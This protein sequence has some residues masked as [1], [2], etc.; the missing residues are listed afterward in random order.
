MKKTLNNIFLL[1]LG[2]II[3]NACDKIEK[4][5]QVASE[6]TSTRKVMIEEFTGHTCGNCPEG[7]LVLQKLTQVLGSQIVAISVHAGSF[8]GS[9]VSGEK[10]RTEF[11][12]QAGEAVAND[13]Q[14]LSYPIATV[15]RTLFAGIRKLPSGAWGTKAS[16]LLATDADITMDITATLDTASRNL[17]VIVNSK[18]VNALSGQYSISIGLIEDSIVDYQK[19]YAGQ[20]VYLAT[21]DTTKYQTDTD[22]PDYMHR[23]VFRGNLN[24]NW[25]EAINLTVPVGQSVE[26]VAPVNTINGNFNLE[27]LSVIA[28]IHNNENKEIIQVEELHLLH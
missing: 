26:Y 24:G 20:R 19:F 17:A 14:I 2:I 12:T 22:V 3:F 13:F 11:R 4:P 16:Q 6:G 15:N 25:G 27:H 23:H 5:Y 10:Y 8:A 18:V 21:N 9:T 7:S 1:G 28:Y